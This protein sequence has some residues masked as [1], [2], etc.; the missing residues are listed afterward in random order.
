MS[1][2]LSGRSEIHGGFCSTREGVTGCG[3]REMTSDLINPVIGESR[4][5]GRV[6]LRLVGVEATGLI[7]G[8]RSILLF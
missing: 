8:S 2:P 6:W 1:F 4:D 5:Y 7:C 3:L